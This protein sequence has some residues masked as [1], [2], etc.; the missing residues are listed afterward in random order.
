MRLFAAFACAVTLICFGALPGH[1]EKRVALV[2]GNGAYQN[3]AALSNPVNDADDMAV[4]L[5]GVGFEVIVE[6]NVNKR[7]LEMAMAIIQ[8]ASIRSGIRYI[9]MP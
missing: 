7:S 4:A 6:R 2:I 9:I 1:A 5:R 8:R 3:T